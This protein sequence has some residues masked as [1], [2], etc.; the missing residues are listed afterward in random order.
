MPGLTPRSGLPGATRA[1]DIDPSLIFRYKSQA[2]LDV[3]TGGRDKEDGAR[4]VLI[5][6]AERIL[7]MEM[8]SVGRYH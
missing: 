5:S 6:D 8:E 3:E 4:E 1:G 2:S 7:N